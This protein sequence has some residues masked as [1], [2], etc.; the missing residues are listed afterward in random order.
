[1]VVKSARWVLGIDLGTTNTAAVVFGPDHPGA[2]SILHG[3]SVPVMPSVVS[4]KNPKMP[5]VGWP[6]KDMMLTDPLTT[7]YGWKRFIGRPERSEYVS[8]Y[9]DRFPFRI[10]GAPNGEIGAQIGD[11]IV[12]FIDVAAM[13]LDQARIQTM[14]TIG[15][16]IADCVIA[17]PA[18]F[19]TAQRDAIKE[20]GRR[21]CLNVVKLV[22]EPTAAALAFGSE[23]HLDS[24]VLIF[25]LGGG[26]FDTTIL[27]LVDN[28]FDVKGTRGDG[29]LGG[30]DL[31]R[32]VLKRLVEHTKSQHQVDITEEPIVAQ[33]VLNAAENAK[34]TLSTENAVRIHVPMI[35]Y[36][37]KG[38]TVDLD[39][40]L[41]REELE[42]LTA[43]LI[44][45]AIGIVDET[46]RS[47]G[48][49][50]SDIENIILVGGQ[51]RMP[52]VR[53][54]IT[55]VFGKPPLT[56]LD[57]DT[58]VAHG[59]AIVARSFGDLG[60]EVLL[61]VLSVPIG[62]VLPGGG[63]RFVFE[64]NRSLPAKARVPL[65]SP[66]GD[67]GMV[68]GLWQ[69]A[70]IT[71]SERQVLGILRIPP[72]LFSVGNDFSLAITLTEELSLRAT[73]HSS[74]QQVPLQV[75]GAR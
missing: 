37:R 63:T 72:T 59:A 58:C 32:A 25:D 47:A 1:M 44:E 35:G 52:L 46:M 39:Y 16:E 36:D 2:I 40:R 17:V 68:V 21:A 4:L 65:D 42:L 50:K 24:R 9:R 64:A 73:F 14:G 10:H 8:R 67:R 19:A 6:A 43:P 15:A 22:N 11:R 30:I 29:F 75:E 74:V 57:P 12:S 27:E 41:T 66:P 45:R 53:R 20:A 61:D 31:D 60:G 13:V 62:I 28:I 54:R 34:C 56:H 33:R 7:I 70:D 5:L 23:R 26:T 18:H 55:E 38:K 69:G 48:Y 3:R 51:T 71:S 49:K